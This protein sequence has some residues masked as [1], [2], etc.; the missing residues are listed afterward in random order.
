MSVLGPRPW[1]PVRRGVALGMLLAC[2]LLAVLAVQ[3]TRAL[4]DRDGRVAAGVGNVEMVVLTRSASDGASSA[5]LGVR[6]GAASLL[7]LPG[8]GAAVGALLA[9]RFSGAP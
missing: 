9:R 6:P 7:L 4:G 2:L 8:A 1:R 3:A 5:S